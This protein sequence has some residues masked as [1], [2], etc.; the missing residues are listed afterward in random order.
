MPGPKERSRVSSSCAR[1]TR[2]RTGTSLHKCFGYP[3][4]KNGSEVR[5]GNA[6]S[7]T[8]GGVGTTS[9]EWLSRYE[10]TNYHKLY[11]YVSD[12]YPTRGGGVWILEVDN[13]EIDGGTGPRAVPSLAVSSG[14]DA[15]AAIYDLYQIISLSSARHACPSFQLFNWPRCRVTC[16]GCVDGRG[17]SMRG[18]IV[19]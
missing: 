16:R 14:M 1:S 10:A 3:R 2:Q 7:F 8:H 12:L 9:K 13:L 15:V 5:Q 4:L 19:E 11:V 18:K 6:M 17:L